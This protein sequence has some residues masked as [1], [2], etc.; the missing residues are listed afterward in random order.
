MKGSAPAR[1]D[2]SDAAFDA[3]GKKGVADLKTAVA[4]GTLLGSVA[5]GYASPPA[6]QNAIYDV[7]TRHFNG[8]I[9]TDEAVAELPKA[10]AN[11]K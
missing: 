6:V 11:A 10:V 4:N 2:V 5:Y 3:C 8:Q 7:V 9:T 1:T